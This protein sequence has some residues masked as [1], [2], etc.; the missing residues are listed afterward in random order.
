MGMDINISNLINSLDSSE[1]KVLLN[2]YY[3][4]DGITKKVNLSD[5]KNDTI[6]GLID[7]KLIDSNIAVDD[8]NL[9]LTSDGFSVCGSVMYEKIQKNSQ[10]FKEK[11]QNLPERAVATIIKRIMWRDT[12]SKESG[13][14]DQIIKSYEL[15]ESVWYERVLLNDERIVNVLDGFYEVLENVGFVKKINGEGWCSPEV[16]N[17]L[18]EEFKNLMDLTWLEEDSLRYYFF[19]YIYAQGQKNLINFAG[20]G[21]E[22]RSMFFNEDS[23]A[24]NYWYQ[25]DNTDPRTLLSSLGLSENRII[26]FLNEMI[27]KEIVSER[28]YPLSSLTF[29]D[30]E[31]KIFVIKDIKKYMDFIEKKFLRHVVDSILE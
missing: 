24:T 14:A 10:F 15:D 22:Y 2:L 23:N 4:K 20:E 11:M 3:N 18:K 13:L 9:S 17:F 19:Y 8:D 30:E 28:Y 26:S 7:K 31:D 1:I 25:I 21:T 5:I 27:K 16:E 29:L 12:T 6:Q